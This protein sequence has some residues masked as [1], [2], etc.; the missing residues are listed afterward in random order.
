MKNIQVVD[1]A[2]NT[3]YWIYEV[4]EELFALLFPSPGQ[5]V[6]FIEDFIERV[7]EDVDVDSLVRA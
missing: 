4:S 3:G 7:G 6:E 5:N 2:L 1:G